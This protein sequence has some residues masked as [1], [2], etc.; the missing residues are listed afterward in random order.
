MK[1][2]EPARQRYLTDTHEEIPSH[3]CLLV[4][5]LAN[6][7]IKDR[8]DDCF[9]ERVTRRDVSVAFQRGCFIHGYGDLLDAWL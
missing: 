1:E 3:F 2:P 7:L 8:P 5:I 4:N 9:S 6:F